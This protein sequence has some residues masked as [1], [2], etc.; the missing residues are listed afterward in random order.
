MGFV[1]VLVSFIGCS[2]AAV[3]KNAYPVPQ[4]EAGWIVQGIPIEFEEQLWVPQ[5][6]IDILLDSEVFLLGE[7]KGVQFFVEKI[8]VR[9]YDR[10]YTKFA[11]NKFRVF[12]KSH[13]KSKKRL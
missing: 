4:D 9:P 11:R 6:N 13:D 8:D 1:L 2:M 12:L 10:L 5:D 7:Y 3:N